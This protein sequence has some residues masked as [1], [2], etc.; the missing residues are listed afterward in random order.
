M[1]NRWSRNYFKRKQS[2]R[3]R[4]VCRNR[5]WC[6]NYFV[7]RHDKLT[8]QRRYDTNSNNWKKRKEK[9]IKKGKEV[10]ARETFRTRNIGRFNLEMG[11]ALTIPVAG[12]REGNGAQY[13]AMLF[14][15]YQFAVVRK[16]VTNLQ[17]PQN[18]RRW[19]TRAVSPKL[20]SL[21]RRRAA[22]RIRLVCGFSLKFIEEKE[23]VGLTADILRAPCECERNLRENLPRYFDLWLLR[24]VFVSRNVSQLFWYPWNS[25]IFIHCS[26][27]VC[28]NRSKMAGIL[29]WQ[30]YRLCVKIGEDFL[31]NFFPIFLSSFGEAR[32]YIRRSP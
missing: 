5:R 32:D 12:E 13:R 1:I 29:S 15:S 8:S 20:R 9:K 30:L 26:R 28:F 17:R 11:I 19:S 7:T 16:R 23:T 2:S 10:F 27:I 3:R 31:E 4:V 22:T 21:G 14:E 24:Y 18:V 6:R 25:L